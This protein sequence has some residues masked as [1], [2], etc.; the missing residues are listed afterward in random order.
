MWSGPIAAGSTPTDRR[1]AGEGEEVLTGLERRRLD[2]EPVGADPPPVV[3]PGHHLEGLE[4][5][6]GQPSLQAL[7]QARVP[8][9]ARPDHGRAPRADR[10][11]EANRALDVLVTDVPED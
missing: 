1:S 4:P 10:R 11:E 5:R 7:E 9:V 3:G 6:L 2:G 8:R